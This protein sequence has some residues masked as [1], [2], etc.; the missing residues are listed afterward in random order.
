MVT[1]LLAP[2]TFAAA[3]GLTGSLVLSTV[4]TARWC[5]GG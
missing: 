1:L 3:W 2:P 4:A 5:S